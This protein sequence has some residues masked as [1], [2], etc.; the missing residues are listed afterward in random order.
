VKEKPAITDFY[1]TIGPKHYGV[2]SVVTLEPG[3]GSISGNNITVNVP[4][5]TVL[6][7]RVPTVVSPGATSNPA[8]GTAW[9]SGNTKN[10]TVTAA[11]GTTET[12]TVTV[13]SK[14]ASVTVVT[15]NL[16]SPDGFV[17]TGSDISAKIKE[18]ITSVTGPD[19]LGTTITLDPADY[20][21]DALYPTT[22]GANTTA[23]LRVPAAKS[24][25]GT[26][27]TKTFDVYIKNNAKAITAFTITSPVNAPGT[28]DQAAKTIT[29]TVPYGTVVTDM[30]A[31]ATHP[32]ASISPPVTPRSYASPV[33]YTVTAEDGSAATYRVTVQVRPGIGAFSITSPVSATGTVNGSAIT[34]TVPYG[35]SLASMGISIEH[36][37]DSVKSLLNSTIQSGNPAT[38]TGQ[39]FS[40]GSR[41]YQV[42]GAN[43]NSELYTVTVTASPGITISG[44]TNPSLTAL[45]FKVN[46]ADLTDLTVNCGSSLTIKI[47]QNADWYIEIA[48]PGAPASITDANTDTVAFNAPPVPGFY[49]VNVMAT[50]GAIDYSGSFGLLVKEP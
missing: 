38:F 22:A 49:S 19:S 21:V 4:Y 40:G 5:G 11:N 44:I 33:D 6:T 24:S 37:G 12:Y 17:K 45:T 43:S 10:Y 47:A 23:T 18:A 50:V 3:S 26:D 39:D 14:I 32:S 42:M 46:N 27:I 41:S 9:G 48:G 29:V 2:G 1:F 8:F 16:L 30:S 31:T 25:T 13:E 34:V 28:V 35:T 7:D 15:G 20:S 36:T